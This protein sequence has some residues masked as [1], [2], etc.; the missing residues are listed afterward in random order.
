MDFDNDETF[1]D[2]DLDDDAL[3]IF[4]GLVRD[5]L[6]SAWKFFKLKNQK[7]HGGSRPGRSRNKD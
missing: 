2:S 1:S 7:K 3:R 6:M 5:N 4:Q